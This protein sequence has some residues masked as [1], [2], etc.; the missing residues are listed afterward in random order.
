MST[1]RIHGACLRGAGA[2][3]VTVE[4]RFEPSD[5]KQVEV[6]LSG[7]PDPVIRES[8]ARLLAALAASRLALPP[9]RYYVNLVPSALKKRGELLD[10][11]L[12]LALCCAAGHAPAERLLDWLFLG[13]VGIDGQIHAVPGGLA[14]AEAALKAGRPR[15]M[16]PPRTAQEAAHLPGALAYAAESLNQALALAL[17]DSAGPPLNA[18][19]LPSREHSSVQALDLVRGQS[20]GKHALMV[21]AAGGHH[22][23]FLGP[24]G[25]GKSSLARLLPALLPTPSVAER[26]EITRVRSALGG[27]PAGLIDERPFRAPHH[28][29]S[30]AG[31]V[32]GG[33]PLV[34]GEISLAHRGVLFLDE[35]TEWK[36]EVLEALRQPLET[37]AIDLARVNDRATLPADFRLVAAMNPCPCGYLGHPS[38]T[39]RCSRPMIARY[40][41]RISGPLFDRIDLRIELPVPR[42]ADLVLAPALSARA[43]G[44]GRAG[45]TSLAPVGSTTTRPEPRAEELLAQVRQTQAFIRERQGALENAALDAAH[46]DRF[47]PLDSSGQALL[48]RAQERR[49][50][51][52]RAIQSL[53][54]VAR[55]LADLEQREEVCVADLACALELRQAGGDA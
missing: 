30:Y 17:A 36:R 38:H 41:G 29:T 2:E 19:P 20:L 49:G 43:G 44:R 11:P 51:S 53:R 46:L 27:W 54:R 23:L 3:L 21:A 28:T 15:L 33:S 40:R 34:A 16:G 48:A 39:C 31:L 8:R 13:E 10:L 42:L 9:G 52:A 37:G 26:I 6:V 4:A 32:G 22:L 5:R 55:T 35:L 14:A 47:A 50:L 24:P 1:A 18:P 45:A 7:L 25:T 12:A